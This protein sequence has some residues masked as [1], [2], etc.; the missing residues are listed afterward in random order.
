MKFVVITDTADGRFNV[1]LVG[2]RK[3]TPLTEVPFRALD[4]AEIYVGVAAR[5]RNLEIAYGT[6]GRLYAYGG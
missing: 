3:V 5:T 4:A 1:N 2:D 6:N